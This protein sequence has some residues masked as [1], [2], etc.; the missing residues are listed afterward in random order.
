MKADY[1]SFRRAASVSLLGLVLQLALGATLLVYGVLGRDH[2][3]LTASYGVLCGAAVWLSLAV[4]FDQH[5]R[6]RI[7]SIE[8]E[9]LAATARQGSVFEEGAGELRVAA[10]RLAWMHSFLLPAVSLLFGTALIALG[11]WRFRS[12]LALLPYDAFPKP[13]ERGWAIP[14]GLI[15]AVVGFVFA[16]FVS[17]MAKQPVWANLRA[18]AGVAVGSA[19]F[20]LAIAAGHFVDIAGSSVV[21]RYLQVVF[22]AFLVLLG[23]EVFLSFL[24]NLYRPRRPGE[25]PRPA[26]DSRVLSFVAAPDR[27][28]ESIGGA[29]NYQFGFEVTSS[30]FY[31]LLS[32]SVL[33]LVVIGLGVV[34]LMT[35]FA[36]VQPHERGLRV[37]YG[38]LAGDADVGP[39]L[40][41]KLP[42]PLERMERFPTSAV[43]RLDLMSLAPANEGPILWTNDHKVDE[44]YALLHPGTTGGDGGGVDDV[45]LLAVE[46]PLLYAV[47]DLA[48]FD[49]LAPA[50]MRDD[51]IRAVARREVLKYLATR[52]VEDVMGAG[53]SETSAGLHRAVSER[54]RALD[55]G[56]DVLFV[57]L[58][59]MHPPRDAAAQFERP[60]VNEQKRAGAI[61][62]G[63]ADAI[64]TLGGAVGSLDL[65]NRILEE[66]RRLDALRASDAPPD[67]IAAQERVAQDLVEQA[68][69][70]A[71]VR[72]A[73][74][75]ADRWTR[76]MRERGRAERYAGQVAAY[77]SAPLVYAAGLYFE[78]LRDIMR[79]ARVY[80]T[81][82]SVPDLRII[83]DLKDQS[84]GANSV[85]NLREQ[86]NQ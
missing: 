73:Q 1:L 32:R 16:R 71:A 21:L 56:I 25:V 43:R 81:S 67:A 11:I 24:L 68:G 22:P 55:A 54:L 7:E 44:V 57:G 8:L 72:I 33:L 40:Y 50:S 13:A 52:S 82:D 20:G 23:A 85:F 28:A 17:G 66:L 84:T 83:A 27:I 60:V 64:A 62:Q 86:E 37:R 45:A 38:R 61:E 80:I 18:G 75:R 70:R 78:T 5:R 48:R 47:S 46:I 74:A 6:E 30:W 76:H 65:A 53:R 36:V 29:I 51:I 63:R 49:A 26:F 41:L 35:F 9:Q 12:G 19:I 59:G 14:I 2:A 58:E 69:G 77:R 10:R 31:Q 3:A 39:G 4:V 79:G 15:L 34:W 42:W